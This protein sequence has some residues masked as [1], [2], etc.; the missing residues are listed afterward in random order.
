MKESFPSALTIAFLAGVR[1]L[2]AVVADGMIGRRHRSN[3]ELVE[4]VAN[5][6]SALFGGLPAT[7]AIAR[8]VTNIRSGAYSPVSGMMHAVFVLLTMLVFAPL[9]SYVPLAG[10][11]SCCCGVEYV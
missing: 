7:G 3:C 9:A 1:S 4:G 5:C 8:T 10:G 6:A 2:S 11:Y